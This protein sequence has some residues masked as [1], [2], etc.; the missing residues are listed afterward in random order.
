MKFMNLPYEVVRLPDEQRVIRLQNIYGSGDEWP[1]I[2]TANHNIFRLD[3][4][5]Q[6]VWQV[7]RVET[8]GQL[9]WEEAHRQAKDADPNCEGCFDPFNHMSL[10][11]FERRAL[12]YKGPYHP[13]EEIV[14]FDEY[15]PGRLLSLAT[16]WWAYDLDPETGVATCTGEQVK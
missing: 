2:H 13:T 12:P 3:A 9:N 8:P 10:C 16:H 1:N 6:V 7:Q 11:F 4:H 14:W 15:A 5:N